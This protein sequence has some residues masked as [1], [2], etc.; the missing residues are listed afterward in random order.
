MAL[1]AIYLRAVTFVSLGSFFKAS[2]AR[3]CFA[4]LASCVYEIMQSLFRASEIGH[5][6]PL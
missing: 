1:L 2:L 3:V 6:G 4:K 5:G